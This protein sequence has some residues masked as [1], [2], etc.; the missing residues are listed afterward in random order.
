MMSSLGAYTEPPALFEGNRVFGAADP[1]IKA[2]GINELRLDD[3]MVTALSSS[4]DAVSEVAWAEVET[5]SPRKRKRKRGD[6]ATRLA[7]EVVNSGVLPLGISLSLSA[8]ADP[9]PAKGSDAGGEG[10]AFD[11]GVMCRP[12]PDAA[13]TPNLPA[14]MGK[15]VSFVT[16][17]AS[18]PARSSA[19]LCT[20]CNDADTLPGFVYLAGSSLV[21]LFE[22]KQKSMLCLPHIHLC[23]R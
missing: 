17:A 9:R 4:E 18:V 23:N 7:L 13:A 3:F 22:T 20:C 1:A 11:S 2:L 19:R 14:S 21:C 15:K 5:A 10:Q 16:I 6:E 12:C 8:A